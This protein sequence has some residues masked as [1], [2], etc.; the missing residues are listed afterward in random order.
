MGQASSRT[1]VQHLHLRQQTEANDNGRSS[2]II[3]MAVIEKRKLGVVRN[4]CL[5]E[6]LYDDN[7]DML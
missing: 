4:I 5:T 1:E 6:A 7:V 2:F 3:K